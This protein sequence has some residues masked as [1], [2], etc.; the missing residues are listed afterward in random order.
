VIVYILSTLYTVLHSAFTLGL[1]R[2]VVLRNRVFSSRL[3]GL[4][5]SSSCDDQLTRRA[6][7]FQV[8]AGEDW[9]VP[10]LGDSVQLGAWRLPLWGDGKNNK[11]L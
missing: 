7:T 6:A 2:C 4:R 10:D 9:K 1:F 3:V 8:E 5:T 11:P